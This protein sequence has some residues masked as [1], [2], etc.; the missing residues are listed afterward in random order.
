M[1]SLPTF[2]WTTINVYKYSLTVDTGLSLELS[3]N[4]LFGLVEYLKCQSFT[5]VI[6]P[7]MHK[8]LVKAFF[9][10]DL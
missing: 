9:A 8:D 7:V 4:I 3:R 6:Y 10:A 1:I 2:S 5:D